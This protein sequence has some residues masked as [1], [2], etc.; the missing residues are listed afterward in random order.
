MHCR[1]WWQELLELTELVK[2]RRQIWTAEILHTQSRVV[3]DDIEGMDGVVT[4]SRRGINLADRAG[5]CS[6]Q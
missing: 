3:S 1:R 6:L 4:R 5:H 2:E